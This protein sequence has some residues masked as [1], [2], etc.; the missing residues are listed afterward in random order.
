MVSLSAGGQ[1][2][3]RPV[4]AGDQDLTKNLTTENGRLV[5]FL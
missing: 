1:P 4:V 3:V 2:L 5:R